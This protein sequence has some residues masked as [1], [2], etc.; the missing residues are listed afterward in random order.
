MTINASS[1]GAATGIVINEKGLRVER[2][3]TVAGVDPYSSFTWVKRDVV[4]RNWRDNTV[5]FEQYGVEFP[6]TWSSNAVSIVTSKYFRGATGSAQRENSLRDLVERVVAVYFRTGVEHGYFRTHE[7]AEAFADEL[8]YALVDQQ[9]SFNSP[10]WFNVGSTSEPQVSACFILSVDDDM[11]SILDWYKEEGRIFKGGSGAGVNL[12]RIRSSREL[13]SSGGNASGPVSF[14][15]GAD[16]SAGTIK[17]GGATRRAAKMVILDVDHPDVREFIN[18]KMIEE[19]KIRILR[20]NGF[21]MDLGGR[22]I[23]SVQYQN[24]NNSV[25]VSDEFMAAVEADAT[26]ALRGRSTGEVV[27]WVKARELF[28]EMAIAAWACADPGI[29]YDG[30]IQSWHTLPNSGRINGTNPCSE[31]L[32]L[33]NSSCN[34]AS[35]RL[36]RFFDSASGRFDVEGFAYLTRLVMIAA[37][38]SV[39]FGYFPTEKIA[40]TTRDIRTIGLGYTDLGALLMGTGVAYDSDEG[41]AWAGAITSMLAAEAYRTS[42]EL[43]AAVGPFALFAPNRDAMLGVITKHRDASVELSG[44]LPAVRGNLAELVAAATASWSDALVQGGRDG[45]R[46]AQS[47]VIAPT[48]TISFFMDAQTTGIE[49]D[50]GLVKFK[51]LADGGSVTIV[52]DMVPT[53]LRSLGYDEEAIE[54]IAAHVITTGSVLDAPGF[55]P[56]HTSVFACAM[57]DNVISAMGHIRMMAAVQPFVSGAISKTVNLTEEATIEDIE[58]IYLDGWRLGLKCL[59]VYRDNCK[60]GQPLSVAGS[61]SDKKTDQA[62]AEIVDATHPSPVP[63]RARLPFQRQAVTTSFNV[64]GAEGYVT[65]GRYGDG[66]L[67]ELFLKMS[68]PGSTLAGVMD[69]FAI[70][71]SLGLQYGV[72][73]EVFA[74]KFL[75]MRF[76][77]SGMTNDPDIRMASSVLDYVFRRLV[78]DHLDADVR[79]ELGVKSVRERIEEVAEGYGQRPALDDAPEATPAQPSAPAAVTPKSQSNASVKDH[80]KRSMTEHDAPLCFTC[81]VPMVRAGS[82]HACPSCGGTSGCS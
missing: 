4:M 11:D 54:T 24:A 44:G 37:E 65:A 12:S 69:A 22:D 29:Q 60:V 53:A 71:V 7:D 42:T 63:S 79:A 78:L 27:E 15:R 33:D 19:D 10:V 75:N 77:P 35:I 8:R 73:L 81:G 67:G 1:N 59:S 52:N 13:L 43:A 72:P 57:G 5:N 47:V 68:K 23:V 36:T 39:T 6:E 76:E 58:Q 41:R 66:E 9:F 46:N 28:R 2:R 31:Y 62:P 82:C 48:G 21:D 20:D 34:L 14:M 49:P 30:A 70:S 40:A 3:N 56:A 74:A 55:D 16:A 51:K 26:F 61:A 32:S 64:G 45:F 18:C 50:L 17:S 80:V 38:I 25:R